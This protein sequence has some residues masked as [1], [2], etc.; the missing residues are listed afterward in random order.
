L[1][2]VTG[3]LLLRFSLV[4]LFPFPFLLV[5]SFPRICLAFMPF[6]VFAF[7]NRTFVE[8]FT[9]V[10]GLAVTTEESLRRFLAVAVICPRWALRVVGGV[11]LLDA[12]FVSLS[13]L[14]SVAGSVTVPWFTSSL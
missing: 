6:E 13:G 12:E 5:D 3:K 7:S 14:P 11:K 4:L 9:N 8:V 10:H 1:T 2:T